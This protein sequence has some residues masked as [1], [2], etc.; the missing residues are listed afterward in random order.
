MAD[1]TELSAAFLG[2]LAENSELFEE[3][4][5][6]YVR[7]HVY[8]RRNFHPEDEPAIA[9]DAR[10]D[11]HFRAFESRMRHTLH[12]LSGRLKRSVPFFSPRYVG[13]MASDLL[14]PALL[15]KII[16]TLY[17]PNN[18]SQEASGETVDMELEVGL[19][20]ARMLGYSC[21]TTGTC[22][23]GHLTSGG[24][25]ADY[26]SLWIALTTR[27]YVPALA[28]AL[29]ELEI[30]ADVPILDDIRRMDPWEQVNLSTSGVLEARR[31][32]IETARKEGG[33]AMAARLMRLVDGYRYDSQG[34]DGFLTTYGLNAP[35]ILVPESAHYSWTKAVKLLG[36]GTSRL[37]KIPV[38]GKMRMSP[39]ELRGHLRHYADAKRPVIA[40]VGVLGTT[41]YGTIDPVHEIV[42]AR[43]ES[44]EY[45]LDFSIHIDG[46]WGGYLASVFRERDGDLRSFEEVRADFNHFPSREV[47]ATFEALAETDSVTIDPHKL[48][49]V[50]YPAGAVIV[51]NRDTALLLSQAA[52]YVFDSPE[53]A[54]TTADDSTLRQ[55]GRFVLEGSKPGSAAAA[56]W[57]THQVLPMHHDGFG[58]LVATTIRNGEAF[59]DLLDTLRQNVK[60]IAHI[61]LPFEP[62]TNLVCL[63]LNP[64]GNRSI[65]EANR[66]TREVFDALRFGPDQPLQVRHFFG[67]YTS[68]THST[69]PR[70]H[71]EKL[72]EALDLDISGFH[73]E[74]STVEGG[75]DHLF[76]LRHTLMNPWLLESPG[77]G[78]YV[79]RY[80]EYL[81]RMI[82]VVAAR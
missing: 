50:P 44:R 71:A 11:P 53:C 55:L 16:T 9:A 54:P 61:E 15:G 23:W 8:W 25:V 78:S 56:A 5:V 72:F 79:E 81:S 51:R 59:Y 36:L 22:A 70:S 76:V 38:D 73:S 42:S 28:T 26:E 19:D 27:L 57:V 40:V 77:N 29:T 66:F 63:A 62:D 68:V 64:V 33:Y 32:A 47:Y 75:A 31:L 43:E 17:N 21:G 35:V 60:G 49:F 48:G 52:A 74:E 39:L 67:S 14:L 3:L 10:Y 12:R 2:P 69:M 46:A 18:V 24:S 41:E 4:L 6:S 45:G 20:L 80:I 13:H 1:V 58:R 37:E 34:L 7:D 65:S 82:C 30:G